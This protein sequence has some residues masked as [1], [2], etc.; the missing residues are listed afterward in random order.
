MRSKLGAGPREPAR[1]L[2]CAL[3]LR[4]LLLIE[5]WR[6]RRRR[7]SRFQT[8]KT[9]RSALQVLYEDNH[10]IAVYKPPGLLTQADRSGDETLMDAVKQFLA[11]KYHKPGRVFLGLIHR[12]DRQVAGVVL[13]AKTS[14]GASRLSA[15]FRERT[16]GKLYH[17]RLEGLISPASGR[18]VN[19]IAQREDAARVR[20]V[21]EPSPDAKAAS[22]TYRTLLRDHDE[23]VVE[24]ALETGR[25]HQIRAQFA[26]IGHPLVGDRLYGARR[27]WGTGGIALCAV[28][29]SF[30]HPVAKTPVV[31]ELPRELNHVTT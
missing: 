28:R 5:I 30:E 20:V 25:K 22:L 13:F 9:D 15:Q 11:V 19:F 1:G 8:V 18:L 23:C 16:V 31:V 14:K 7:Y 26:H 3:R 21:T 6:K 4:G 17:A 12:L 27:S 29:L 24:V 2:D 10:L